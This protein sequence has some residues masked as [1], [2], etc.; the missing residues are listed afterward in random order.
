M[1]KKAHGNPGRKSA[2]YNKQGPFKNSR[3][4]IR[5]SILKELLACPLLDSR[6]LARR[7]GIDYTLGNEIL[8]ELEHEGFILRNGGKYRLV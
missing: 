4:Q 1:L 3:R 6:E 7:L 8:A 2:M 5:G